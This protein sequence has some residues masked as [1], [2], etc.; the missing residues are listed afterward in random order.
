M[1]DRNAV[2][3]SVSLYFEFQRK[4][5]EKS[6]VFESKFGFTPEFKAGIN[7]GKVTVAEVGH[8]KREIAY[9][10]DV[11]NTGARIQA[12]CNEFGRKLLVSEIF[13]NQLK[14]TSEFKKELMG[15]INLKGKQKAIEIYAIERAWKT[16]NGDHRDL[17]FI[18]FLCLL[19]FFESIKSWLC[20]HAWEYIVAE[21]GICNFFIRIQ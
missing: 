8:F 20:I 14:G 19:P 9:H 18:D 5:H 7:E 11:L 6:S 4:L 1:K 13:A 16:P 3:N 12:M 2:Q 10:G 17:S 15:K 21:F